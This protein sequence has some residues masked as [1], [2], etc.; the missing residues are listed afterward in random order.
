MSKGNKSYHYSTQPT[1]F[2]A[3]LTR[4]KGL[5]IYLRQ[6]TYQTQRIFIP[7]RVPNLSNNVMSTTTTTITKRLSTSPTKQPTSQSPATTKNVC[8]YVHR[9]YGTTKENM[10]DDTKATGSFQHYLFRGESNF[11]QRVVGASRPRSHGNNR[12]NSH[13]E[14]RYISRIRK[15][16][17]SVRTSNYRANAATTG[18]TRANRA[19]VRTARAA[20]SNNNSREL[21]RASISTRRDELHRTRR[22]NRATKGNRLARILIFNLSNGTRNYNALYGIKERV[23]KTSSHL[24]T[25]REREISVDKRRTMI[26]ANRSRRQRGNASSN[27]RY[28]KTS[29]F[30]NRRS[31]SRAVTSSTARETGRTRKSKDRS[32]SNRR[33]PR[34][35]LSREKR[36]LVSGSFRM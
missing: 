18:A 2:H 10:G 4:N 16:F 23:A 1:I 25:R 30:G 5:Q 36:S 9:P 34:S 3:G 7:S 31:I 29:L 19:N 15:V 26:R 8:Y 32:R 13:N 21:A 33:Q 28:P 24:V 12:G 11:F 20:T 17:A 6:S 22:D 27:K 14:S 35:R